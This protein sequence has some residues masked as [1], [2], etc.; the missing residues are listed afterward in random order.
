M[1]N[2]NALK[3]S[4]EYQAHLESWAIVDPD[5]ANVKIPF[6][7]A[8]ANITYFGPGGHRLEGF[9]QTI[10]GLD[11]EIAQ[12]LDAETLLHLG[13]GAQFKSCSFDHKN[14]GRRVRLMPDGTIESAV[15]Q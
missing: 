3:F 6:D 11:M 12:H 15:R 2:K 7:Q 8:V 9:I 10:H 13:V 1:K 5:H 14:P 4:I